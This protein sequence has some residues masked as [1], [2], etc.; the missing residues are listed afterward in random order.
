VAIGGEGKKVR[1]AEEQ[2][3]RRAEDEMQARWQCSQKRFF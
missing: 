3:A 2:K 1:R